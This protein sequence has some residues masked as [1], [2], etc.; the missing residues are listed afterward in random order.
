MPLSNSFSNLSNQQL[1]NEISRRM[2]DFDELS[3]IREEIMRRINTMDLLQTSNQ[4]LKLEMKQ[5]I[6]KLEKS[7]KNKTE[8]LSSIRNRLY[9][10]LSSIIL[11]SENLLHQMQEAGSESAFAVDLIYKEAQNLNFALNNLT[12]AAELEAG[13]DKLELSRFDANTLIDEGLKIFSGKITENQI[14]VTVDCSQA[15]KVET[16][17]AKLSLVIQ[18]LISNAAEFS[19]IRGKVYISAWEDEKEIKIQVKDEGIGFTEEQAHDIFT[20][21][22]QLQSGSDRMYV[23]PGIGLCLVKDI[24][25]LLEGKVDFESIP[26]KGSTFTVTIPKKMNKMPGLML[27]E[28]G[29]LFDSVMEDPSEF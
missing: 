3:E 10:P 12:T 21:F 17:R 2:I 6:K 22:D 23:G 9:N 1:V 5:I 4:S 24:V 13:E 18:N 20:R 19:K 14:D 8:F 26:D 29:L 25:D 7:E 15:V 28:R 11:F 27:D 16:D